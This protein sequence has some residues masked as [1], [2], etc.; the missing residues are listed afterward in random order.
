V[1]QYAEALE[2]PGDLPNFTAIKAKL[3]ELA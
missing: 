2:S 1:I 3:A